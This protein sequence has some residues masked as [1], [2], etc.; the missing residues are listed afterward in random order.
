MRGMSM[1]VNERHRRRHAKRRGSP[2][3]SLAAVSG[4]PSPLRWRL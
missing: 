1:E 2:G 3:V 4:L